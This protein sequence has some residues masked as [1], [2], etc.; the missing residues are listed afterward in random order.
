MFNLATK[1]Q[2]YLIQ[3]LNDKEIQDW[4]YA[5]NPLLA[6]RIKSQLS[7]SRTDTVGFFVN[8]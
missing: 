5:L 3:T 7:R 8:N 1:N 4:L 6:G 2:N